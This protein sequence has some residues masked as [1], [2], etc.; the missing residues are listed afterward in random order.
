MGLTIKDAGLKT[1]KHV[2]FM[3]FVESAGNVL[4]NCYTPDKGVLGNLD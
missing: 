4:Q 1:I 2:Y 3:L